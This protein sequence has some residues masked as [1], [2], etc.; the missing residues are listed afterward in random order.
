MKPFDIG[1]EHGHFLAPAAQL[2]QGRVFQDLLAHLRADIAGDGVTEQMFL[3]IEAQAAPQGGFVAGLF[4]GDL[5][6]QPF[7][8][9]I[10][11]VV[12]QGQVA[13]AGI[14]LMGD[15]QLDG[16]DDVQFRFVVGRCRFIVF[17]NEIP[18]SFHFSSLISLRP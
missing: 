12:G 17:H 8:L 13:P 3:L 2:Q 14:Q 18:H 5:P 6:E 10:I 7:Q 11:A 15:G 1:K 4:G 16:L 9:R